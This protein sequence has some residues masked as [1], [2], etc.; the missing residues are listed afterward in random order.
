MQSLDSPPRPL[1]PALDSHTMV[2]PKPDAS[3]GEIFLSPRVIDTATFN[4]FAQRLRSLIGQADASAQSLRDTMA[5]AAVAKKSIDQSAAAQKDRLQAAVKVLRAI[6]AVGAP[7]IEPAAAPAAAPVK[8]DKAE[9]EKIM[10]EARNELGACADELIAR[11]EHGSQEAVRKADT[12][13]FK[14][15]AAVSHAVSR[16]ASSR[17]QLEQSQE[18]AQKT[19]GQ[20]ASQGLSLSALHTRI[21][22][23]LKELEEAAALTIA[24]AHVRET[25]EPVADTDMTPNIE[26]D[27]VSAPIDGPL[28]SLCEQAQQLK[29]EIAQSIVDGSDQLDELNTRRRQLAGKVRDAILACQRAEASMLNTTQRMQT[30]TLA[31]SAKSES[32]D[33]PDS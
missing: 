21:T 7:A 20:L 31:S 14:L 4:E 12:Q 23:S 2:E 22:D 5:E 16:A 3:V 28:A 32:A 15:S 11:V 26:Q 24:D 13:S 10:T 19:S 9:L 17:G 30:Q 33:S 27:D 6:D 8:L 25:D 1:T 18:Q 29:D